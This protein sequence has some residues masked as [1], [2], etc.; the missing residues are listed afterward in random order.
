MEVVARKRES[1]LSIILNVLCFALFAVMAGVFI[2]AIVQYAID[3][4]GTA[5]MNYNGMA[6][7]LLSIGLVG[8]I[9]GSVITCRI[10][11]VYFKTPVN[12]IVYENGVF[13]S[14]LGEFSPSQIKNMKYTFGNKRGFGCQWGKLRIITKKKTYS[15]EFVADVGRAYDRINQIRFNGI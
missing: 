9:I 6:I 4:K 14:S 7:F 3:D 13:K 1:G 8:L 11:I 5:E 10:I 12:I 15:F 2:W